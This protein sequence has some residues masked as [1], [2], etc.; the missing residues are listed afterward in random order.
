M[1]YNIYKLQ[2]CHQML[3]KSDRGRRYSRNE[4]F[5]PLVMLQVSLPEL[6]VDGN[7]HKLNSAYHC[8]LYFNFTK[9]IIP[10]NDISHYW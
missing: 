3:K 10:V 4:I 7:I 6:D 9:K 1:P 2:I 5:F 8:F